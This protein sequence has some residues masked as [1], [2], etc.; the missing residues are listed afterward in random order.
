MLILGESRENNL[1]FMVEFLVCA[2]FEG[3]RDLEDFLSFLFV[4]QEDL[5]LEEVEVEFEAAE[6]SFMSE[7][8]EPSE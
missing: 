1:D 7:D 2:F 8:A 4:S 6:A 3:F 5:D